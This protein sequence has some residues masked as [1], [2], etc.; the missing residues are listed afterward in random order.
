M[1][2]W[3]SLMIMK[4]P[5][6]TRVLE[7]TRALIG[8]GA[9]IAIGSQTLKG[10]WA[11]LVRQAIVMKRGK[12]PAK[13]LLSLVHPKKKNLLMPKMRNKSPKRLV[14][15]VINPLSNLFHLWYQMI[16]I[17]EEIPRPSH[18]RIREEREFLEIKISI[19]IIKERVLKRNPLKNISSGI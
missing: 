11:L 16:R 10:I 7:W 2:R 14:R 19:E 12:R 17:K 4:M 13:A 9:L 1:W 6:V 3:C 15:K 8:V 5:A 18:P